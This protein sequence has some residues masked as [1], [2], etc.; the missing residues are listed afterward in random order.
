MVSQPDNP[1]FRL[2]KHGR[3]TRDAESRLTLLVGST[4]TSAS[5]RGSNINLLLSVPWVLF[6]I[7]IS[8]ILLLLLLLLV[9][10]Y[11]YCYHH[12]HHN[13]SHYHHFHYHCYQEPRFYHQHT[14]WCYSPVMNHERFSCKMPH[15]CCTLQLYHTHPLSTS[16][17]TEPWQP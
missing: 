5:T 13:Y 10:F 8:Y 3:V 17:D 2:P 16:D 6:F 11:F 1:P 15:V 7:S 14:G 12:H 4:A 9:S